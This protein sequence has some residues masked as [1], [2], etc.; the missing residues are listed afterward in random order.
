MSLPKPR[1]RVR[2]T[3]DAVA[4]LRRLQKKDPQIVREVFKK[5]LLLERATDAGEPL[6]GT[7]VG[8]RKLIIGNRDYRIVWRETTD[9]AHQPVLDIAE[10]WAAGVRSDSEIY[11]EMTRRVNQLKE[12]GHPQTRSLTSVISEMGRIYSE[13]EAHP[14]PSPAATLP[15]WLIQALK[16]NLNLSP[17]SITRLSLDEAQQLLVQ[18]WGKT[19]DEG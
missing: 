12:S 1:A 10:I 3:D 14:E 16:E 6:I 7:L 13:I 4:D 2:L 17:E 5:M 9:D 15:T 19:R 8:F 11:K 18:H